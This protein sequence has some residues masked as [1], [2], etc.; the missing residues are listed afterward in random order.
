[1]AQCG[2]R[3]SRQGSDEDATVDV[4]L[5]L[6]ELGGGDVREAAREHVDEGLLVLARGLDHLERRAERQAEARPRKWSA[7]ND[8][9]VAGHG[10]FSSM[11]GVGHEDN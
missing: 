6:G 7:I 2:C 11:R 10:L 5:N 9:D 3:W 8:A 4:R 1:M